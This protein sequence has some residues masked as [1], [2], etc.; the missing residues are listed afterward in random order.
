MRGIP[1]IVNVIPR[2][3]RDTVTKEDGKYV[4]R[5][6]WIVDTTGSNLLE[7]L[8]LDFI[9]PYR[10]YTNNVREVAEVLGMEAAV[11]VLTMEMSDVLPD[12]NYHHLSLI[13]DK[14]TSLKQMCPVFRSG[15]FA[16]NVGPLMKSSFEMHSEVL[17]NAAR[18]GEF[19][20][21]R[22]VS[23]NVMLGQTGYFGTSAFQVFLDMKAMQTLKD[24]QAQLEQ[25]REQMLADGFEELLEKDDLCSKSA[26]TIQNHLDLIPEQADGANAC[27]DGYEVF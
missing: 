24:A 25:D 11:Q 16:D 2:E 17:L 22:V 21:A 4:K 1:G 12:I 20:N 19:D 6:T 5:N 7:V 14:M 23:A 27:D 8:G 18:H 9:D 26:V 15:I 10:T 3:L 13:V